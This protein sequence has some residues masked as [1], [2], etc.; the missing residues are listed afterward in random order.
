MADFIE[1]PE[2]EEI[3]KKLIVAWEGLFRHID[4]SKILWARDIGPVNPRSP[5]RA[6]SCTRVRPPYTLLNPD[7]FYIIA[8]HPRAKWEELDSRRRAVLVMHELL[9]IPEEFGAGALKDHDVKD[10]KLLVDTLGSDYLERNDLPDL[11]E[12]V[13]DLP[14][15]Q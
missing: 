1:D 13:I 8:V 2:M 14:E 11:L 7:V 12:G 4:A 6:G 9:H 10:F 3:G 15:E 5:K